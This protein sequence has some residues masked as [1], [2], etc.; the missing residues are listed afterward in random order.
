MLIEHK[1]RAWGTQACH[2]SEPSAALL[3][4]SRHGRTSFAD[5]PLATRTITLSPCGM[6]KGVMNTMNMS[7]CQ[8]A[9]SA[10]RLLFEGVH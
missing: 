6:K 7:A 5:P 3:F 1:S 8:S 9:R 4:P 10:A 2:A